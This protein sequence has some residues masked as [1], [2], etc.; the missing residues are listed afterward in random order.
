MNH[1]LKIEHNLLPAS[2][3]RGLFLK[4]NVTMSLL[5]F[6]NLCFLFYGLSTAGAI[7]F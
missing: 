6:T 5:Q 2:T 3:L 7:M 1:H 4:F